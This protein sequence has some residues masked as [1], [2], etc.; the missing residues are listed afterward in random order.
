MCIAIRVYRFSCC[1]GN[2]FTGLCAFAQASVYR[3]H[4][5]S[6]PPGSVDAMWINTQPQLWWV[7][8]RQAPS[9][10]WVDEATPRAVHAFRSR[11][12]S[13]YPHQNFLDH[14]D[15][16]DSYRSEYESKT[17]PKGCIGTKGKGGDYIT[18]RRRG[19]Q[20][21]LLR[22]LKVMIAI[23]A[24]LII[25]VSCAIIVVS[26]APY[27]SAHLL[28]AQRVTMDSISGKIGRASCRERV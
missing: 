23:C 17:L 6:H 12:T 4:K 20:T 8:S 9:T 28:F 7:T 15:L 1:K 26:C 5:G 21:S 27:F 10:I 11:N 19:L 25:I 3:S 13:N 16:V 14:G 2:A 22:S 24:R 18:P